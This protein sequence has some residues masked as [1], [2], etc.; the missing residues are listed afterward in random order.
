MSSLTST[1][2][3]APGDLPGL[4]VGMPAP[5]FTL[6]DQF[7]QDVTMSSFV[8][9]KAV[10]LVFFPWAFSNV[11]TGELTGIRDRLDEF[12]TFDTEVLAVST[13]ATY[14]LR[15]FADRDG[16][17]FPLLS[18][19]W[20]HGAVASA[21]GVLDDALGVARRSSFVVD[22]AGI[23]RWTV[24]NQLPDGRDLG[25]HLAQLHQLA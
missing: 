11:C 16:L 6:R 24:H 7:G 1:D 15:V 17:N 9:R 20:P 14:S 18:D 22:K 3:P 12:L 2:P 4:A 23:V 21:Y 13:D 19:F 10:A 5:D 25:D 8:G